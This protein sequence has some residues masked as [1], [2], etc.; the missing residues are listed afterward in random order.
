MTI[1]NTDAF[2]WTGVSGGLWSSAVNWL[3][4]GKPATVVPGAGNAVT[5]A[6]P[7]GSAYEVIGG[8]GA[9]ASLALT[10]YVALSGAYKTTSLSVGAPLT[11]PNSSSFVAGGLALGAGSTVTTTTANLIDGSASIAGT[12]AKL[13]ASGA[14]TVGSPNFNSQIG[15]TYTSSYGASGSLSVS[16]GGSLASGDLNIV[17]GS[18]SASGVGTTVAVS[19]GLTLGVL[20]T[21]Y[22]S[23]GTN[24]NSTSGSV[25]I[26]GGAKVSVVGAV[27]AKNGS[28]NVTGAGS[29]L[30]AASATFY[31]SYN[32]S[33]Y[34]MYGS[35]N[36]SYGGAIQLGGLS[37]AA[38]GASSTSTLIV[39][40]DATSKIEIG[41]T[42]N[43][44]LGAITIDAGSTLAASVA[45]VLMGAVVDNGVISTTDHLTIS[46]ALSGA[47]QVQIGANGTLTLNGAGGASDTVAFTG[48][49]AS[50][51]IGGSSVYNGSVTTYTPYAVASKLT[52]LTVGDSI[53]V[54]NAQ[55]TSAVYT[56]KG[57]NTGTL[58]L[59]TGTTAVET[60]TLA[61]NY[62]G[63]NFFLSPTTS[64][65]T[66]VSL[67]ATPPSVPS[68]VSKTTDAFIW[69]GVSGGLWS[70]AVNWLDLG[71]PATVVPGAGNAVTVAGPTGSAYEVIGGGGASASL[72]LTGYV[73][74]SG[75]YKTTSLSVGAP[76]TT[77]NSSSFV[78]GGL[79]LGAGSTVTTTTANLIDG[80]ASIAGTGAKLAA[81]G[82]VT[83]GSPNF[84]SQIGQ[85]YTSSYG[86]SGS[87]SVSGGGSLASGDL[88]IVEGSLS[89]SGVGTTVAVSGGLTL[90][91]LTTPYVSG[92][93]NFNSTSGSVTISGGAKISVVGAVQAKNGSIN[94][95]GAGSSLTAASATFYNSYNSSLYAMYGSL[96]ASYGGAIQLG[97]LSLA[98]SGAS[99]TSTLIVNVDATSKIEIGST[100]NAALGAITID[101]GSTL[102]ASVAGVLMGAVVDNGVISTTD[103][104]TI[105]GALSG[106]GQVQIGANGTLTLNGAGG[107]SDTVA[108]TGAGASFEI[109]GSSVYNGSVTTYTPY[110]VA[111]KLTGLTVGDSI[112][113]DNAQLTSAVYT[114]K[115]SNTGTLALMTGTTA[116]ETLTLAGNYTGSNFF[117]SPTTSGG[118][119]VSLLATPPS[120]P[121]PVSKTTDA[122]IWTGVSG[123]LWSSAV[124]WLD[125]GKPATVVPG[126]GNAVT[127][128]GP[129]GSAYEVIG[130][131][132]ASASLALTGYV[133]LSGAYKT[134]SLSVGAP[135]TTP[136]SSSFVAGGLALGA[137]STVTTTTANLIDGS[138]SI[139]GTGAKLAAS[140]A[141]TVGSPNF[142]SQ[143]GQAYTSSYGASGSLSVSGG[144]SLASGDLNIVEGSLSASGVGTTVAV[145]G[146]LTLGVLTTPYVSGGTNFNS[147]S[148]SVTISGGAKISVVGAVQ[149]KNGSINVTG[150]GSSLTAA[151]ATFYNSYNSSL[152]AMYGSLNASYGGAIQLGGLSLAASGASSTSTLIV[153]VDATSKI[154]I[155]STGN[156]A[157][158]AITI[159]AG[160][161]FAASVAGVLMGA[162]V[163]N[164][165][166]STTDHLT[167]SGA[168]SG[169]GQVQIGANGTLTLYGAGGA[170][171][172]VAFTGAGASFEIGGSS[173]L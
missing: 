27:Q 74:L 49:G 163:D 171:D 37:L 22:V 95:T 159:D 12:G 28:I 160:S 71:K 52:G 127:V 69:T 20:T 11:T 47:G 173:S 34:A 134:T 100:G 101:A 150:A 7:T 157:L 132:G 57:S 97:G 147:T 54:D 46:G 139:A 64:G 123:G 140:G 44:A 119:S 86:A 167:I 56:Y 40:V 126:A 4:L 14:V 168:L 99:S 30:T 146:G 77:P 76:L 73:A 156:A 92:G 8:G 72:A 16:G 26:S 61:G 161:T 154:E 121:S 21:P 130:G 10:G 6:G 155:G 142:N 66:S 53:I 18:L 35:L 104:L 87:L 43:A 172:T 80:S 82:A 90:G 25:T 122:F 1:S 67:L 81:S 114:Y 15:Q 128:A 105:S 108:F 31:N 55:L 24:F 29:S 102:A 58:A 136:N 149:A 23:G 112:I 83:V 153:N 13:A 96:N 48:A 36:A 129:T 41:S 170:S 120:V 60:L 68:P 62:T 39:N 131:G 138:A 103:H 145:S 162:V 42:G 164:G 2:I 17:E 144:G 94:V 169:A 51:E 106:A 75:A 141:V 5:V 166:I 116:V 89:A 84:N 110:A 111:S 65:G 124:N 79:A 137:G 113:V 3:D 9:S 107:A 78:A 135:L 143:I 70:S 33:L 118:T 38:S 91:V 98:A 93:T 115:G 50:F 109:G 151:S 32:S 85:T 88:N 59:M 148:G 152:Y 158:G 125:L 165:V 133:A 19:G 117:L 45:G 63:S